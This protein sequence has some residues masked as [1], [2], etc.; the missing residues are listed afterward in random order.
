MKIM[1]PAHA[2]TNRLAITGHVNEDWYFCWS[3]S[4]PEIGPEGCWQQ[5][6]ELAQEI[7]RENEKLKG[8]RTANTAEKERR[9]AIS[10]G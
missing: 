1:R 2:G 4:N 7:L 5:W 9:H 3:P 10:R 8:N 6:V